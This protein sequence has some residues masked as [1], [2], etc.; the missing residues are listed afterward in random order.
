MLAI[1]EEGNGKVCID[2]GISLRLT[3]DIAIGPI[4]YAGKSLLTVFRY[5]SSPSQLTVL[6]YPPPMA[7]LSKSSF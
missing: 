2:L 1:S 5:V 7:P 3:D 6:R 4:L